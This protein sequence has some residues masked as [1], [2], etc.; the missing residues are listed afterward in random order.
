MSMTGDSSWTDAGLVPPD[1][2]AL[3]GPDVV[4]QELEVQPRGDGDAGG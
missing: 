2:V 1:E 4:E 3:P